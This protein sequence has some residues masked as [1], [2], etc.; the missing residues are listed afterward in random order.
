MTTLHN[1]SRNC[2]FAFPDCSCQR[3]LYER[4]PF[5][6]CP[7][8][9]EAFQRRKNLGRREGHRHSGGKDQRPQR[10][11]KVSRP[12]SLTFN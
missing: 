11:F 6:V 3:A 1:K 5:E 7:E 2:F 9:A 8:E 4:R 12:S 10:R